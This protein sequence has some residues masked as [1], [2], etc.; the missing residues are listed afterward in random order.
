MSISV[1]SPVLATV[2][3]EPDLWCTYAAVRTLRWLGMPAVDVDGTA[4]YLAGRG[5]TDGG[6]AWSRGMPS[7]A[8]ATF[9][10]VQALRDLG[11]TVPALD[12]TARWVD[13]TWSGDAYAM[14]PGQR[15]DVWATHFS[16]RTLIEACGTDVADRPALLAWLA[17][18]QR[19]DGGLTWSPTHT[20]ADVR[21]CF[22]GVAAWRAVNSVAPV[23]P[24]WHVPALVDWLTSMRGQDGG[25]RFGAHAEL[26]CLWA[27][28]RAS[29]A[30]AA[31]GAEPAPATAAY[32]HG[33]RGTSGGFTRWPGYPVEDVWAAF[34]AVGTLDAVG[35]DTGALAG[36]VAARLGDFACAGGGFT[37][38]EPAVAGDVLTASAAVLSAR[39]DAADIVPWLES[40]QLPNEG[41]VMYMPGRGSEV[42]CTAWALAAGAFAGDPDG[43]QRIAEWLRATQNPDG[44]WGYWE[45]RGS[46]MVSTAAAIAVADRLDAPLASLVDTGRM[47]DFVAS[48]AVGDGYATVPGTTPTFRAGAQA[49]RVL[50]S[51]GAGDRDRVVAL[52]ARHRVRGGGFANEG[53]RIPDLLSTYEAVLAADVHGIPVDAVHIGQFVACVGTAAGTAWTP[54][55]PPTGGALADCLHTLLR[56]RLDGT[57]RDLPPVTLS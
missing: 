18:L 40:C 26:S 8:W 51:V 48:C 55:G 54:L 17:A 25:F 12:A 7:D 15:P 32:V 13:R 31:L 53:N 1:A 5:N 29:A 34:C 14:T 11:R 50:A 56:A 4:A 22:Y 30:L 9:Y 39:A 36:A 49:G 45:G 43:R 47:V 2:S 19:P 52:L 38:R 33:Q 37:Y 42:R 27:T 3:G 10:S 20:D 41:G 28:Y 57:V 21:A 16:T 23:R 44:G 46:D 6:Y 35:A 24:P